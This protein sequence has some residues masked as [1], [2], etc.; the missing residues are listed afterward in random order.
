VGNCS[1]QCYDNG[2]NM[3]GQYK[4]VQARLLNQNPREFF[5][6]CAS[7]RLNLV[8]GNA[9]KSSTRAIHFFGTI[10][11]IYTIFAASTGRWII[12]TKHFSSLDRQNVVRNKMEEQA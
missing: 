1:A 5:M 12:F 4:G 7:H 6:P 3:A 8:I 2:A 11:Q 10:E 9:V